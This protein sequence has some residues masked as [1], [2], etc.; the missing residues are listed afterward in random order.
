M[1]Q[2]ILNHLKNIS[3]WKTDRKLVIFSVDDYGN[4]RIGSKA[5]QENL[6]KAKIGLNSH[7]DRFDA[8]ETKED[9]ECLYEVLD[10]VK[11]KNGKSAI[12]TPYALSCNI[13]FDAM[14]NNKYQKYVYEILPKTYDKLAL[15]DTFAYEGAWNVWQE[16]IK[17]GFMK[18]QF[19]GREH[20]NLNIFNDLLQKQT[21]NLIEV[22][23]QD[24]YVSIPE[25]KNYKNGWT[26]AYSFY[27]LKETHN[28][29]QNVESGLCNFKEV[30]G[31]DASVFTPPAQQ[32]PLHLEAELGSYGL[33]YIDRPRS[34]KR[35]LGNG[36]HQME[37]HK[38]GK[39]VHMT[40]LVRNVV[41]EPTTTRI[42]NW[43]DFTFKQ[44]EAAFFWKKPAN[45]S[46]HRVNF[47]GYIDEGNRRIG[48]K[49]LQQLLHKIVKRWPDV[50]FISADQLGEIISK[51]K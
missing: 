1:K 46:S 5:A 47:G 7:F 10:S 37:T 25:H 29:L 11:D 49:A 39:G 21:N 16:G 36:Q 50:E 6:S 41:F 30:F 15:K 19:H 2:T 38:L 33:A 31:Y 45:I 51:E 48:L 40:E 42:T 4:V 44:I 34:L 26:A 28:F 20:F 22:L 18:P 13:D 17:N 14:R 12:F 32:F 24:S 23:N 35:H 27:D 9:L 43:V 8:L 3:G